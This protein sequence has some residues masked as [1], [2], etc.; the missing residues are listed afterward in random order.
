MMGGTGPGFG[1]YRSGPGSTMGGYGSSTSRS[2]EDFDGPTAVAMVGRVAVLI[3]ALALALFL[4]ARRR[5]SPLGT[6]KR[7]FGKG[8]LT[9]DEYQE[10]KRLLEGS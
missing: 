5:P 3:G 10:R 4:L 7:R 9:R 2:D 1:S 8:R 6:L